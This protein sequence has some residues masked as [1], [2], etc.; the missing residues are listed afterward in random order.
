VVALSYPYKAKGYPHF[1]GERKGGKRREEEEKGAERNGKR[2]GVG[3]TDVWGGEV[4]GQ[5]ANA[6]GG[7]DGRSNGTVS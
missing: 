1:W 3:G 4:R 6:T 5:A 2:R 7:A